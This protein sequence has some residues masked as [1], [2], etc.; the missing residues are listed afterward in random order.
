MTSVT[1][2]WKGVCSLSTRFLGNVRCC[3][4][5]LYSI[6][7]F[8]QKVSLSFILWIFLI[9][10]AFVGGVSSFV[11][12]VFVELLCL[13]SLTGLF[14]T[15]SASCCSFRIDAFNVGFW[16]GNVRGPPMRVSISA[17]SR[18]V[19]CQILFFDFSSFTFSFLL[20]L[21]FISCLRDF[22]MALHGL[23]KITSSL[24][25]I[26]FTFLLC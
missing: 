7:N 11:Q 1:V 9:L 23:L 15:V 6:L 12:R 4:F 16:L 2:S 26:S 18:L 20:L 14:L 19:T 24:S 5:I 10:Q 21:F 3:C 13:A 8:P 25:S 22:C 17:N